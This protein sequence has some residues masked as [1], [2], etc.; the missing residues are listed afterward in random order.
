MIFISSIMVNGK[1]LEIFVQGLKIL[2]KISA[3]H[4]FPEDPVEHHLPYAF[5]GI[6]EYPVYHPAERQ[7][8]AV[9][10]IVHER[11]SP[12]AGGHLVH[13]ELP[14]MISPQVHAHTAAGAY[15]VVDPFGGQRIEEASGVP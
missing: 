11:L 4:E 3:V 10:K 14:V 12:I 6:G 13:Y 5:S 8:G 2:K 7:L 15:S 1:G 9:G